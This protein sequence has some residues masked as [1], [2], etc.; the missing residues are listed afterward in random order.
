MQHFSF[1]LRHIQSCT[2]KYMYSTEQYSVHRIVMAAN[3]T[4]ITAFKIALVFIHGGNG[5]ECKG[6][7]LKTLN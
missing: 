4:I 6:R 2:T 7:L 5:M 3:Y 1:V